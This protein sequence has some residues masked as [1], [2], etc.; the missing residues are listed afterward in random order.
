MCSLQFCI[1]LLFYATFLILMINVYWVQGWVF[2]CDI[3]SHIYFLL[4]CINRVFHSLHFLYFNKSPK[5]IPDLGIC[6][7]LVIREPVF[8]SRQRDWSRLQ[9]SLIC[10]SYHK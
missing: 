6:V 5:P 2:Y 10:Q 1:L 4:I 7:Q 8:E 3:N 9:E